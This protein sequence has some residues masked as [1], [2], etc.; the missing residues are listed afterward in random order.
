MMI[1]V[2]RVKLHD[3]IPCGWIRRGITIA[4]RL[5]RGVV[6]VLLSLA[7]IMTNVAYNDLSQHRTHEAY[8]VALYSPVA[9]C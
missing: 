5:R 7:L 2:Q 8:I 1:I 9:S 4:S 3:Y 6:D